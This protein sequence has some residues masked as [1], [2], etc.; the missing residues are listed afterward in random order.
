MS[1]LAPSNGRSGTLKISGTGWLC[2]LERGKWIAVFK[3][4]EEQLREY[5]IV[6]PES[7]SPTMIES[8]RQ[9]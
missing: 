9:E 2:V 5:R 7:A 4:T 3:L 8:E 6:R 1:D